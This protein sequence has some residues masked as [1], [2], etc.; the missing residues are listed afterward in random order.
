MIR[1][2]LSNLIDYHKD[3]WKIQLAIKINF[4][5]MHMHSKNIVILAGYETND[6][7][8]KLYDFLLER[9]KKGLE[10]KMKKK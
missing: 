7:I 1:P 4:I 5:S 2:Y 10:E 3:E 8:E 9:Y 6:I